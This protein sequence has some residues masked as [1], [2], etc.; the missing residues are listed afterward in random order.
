MMALL[1]DV[2]D[3]WHEVVA[4]PEVENSVDQD[5]VA[6]SGV[7]CRPDSLLF[8]NTSES[9]VGGGMQ[10]GKKVTFFITDTRLVYPSTFNENNWIVAYGMRYNI[11]AIHVANDS[12]GF[13]HYEV[14][15]VIGINR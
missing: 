5:Q 12:V 10:T 9:P 3:I 1:T 2:C 11:R 13:H 4:D 6:I 8:R 15:T 14:D 7:P